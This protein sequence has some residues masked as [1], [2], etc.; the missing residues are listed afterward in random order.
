MVKAYSSSSKNP[1]CR[2]YCAVCIALAALC[3]WPLPAALA[4]GGPPMVTDDP[5][6][7]GNGRWE[8]NLAA[9]GN[10]SPGLAELTVPD[11]DINYGWGDHLQLK[12]DTAWLVADEAG[13]G[14]T[15]GAGAPD[16]GVKWRFLDQE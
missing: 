11:A 12:L 8:I 3:G 4:Q 2:R 16:L 14:V 10:H 9:I 6:T 15:S 1:L 13:R 5:N 7:P